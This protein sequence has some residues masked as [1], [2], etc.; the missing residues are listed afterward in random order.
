MRKSWKQKYEEEV[1]LMTRK[2]E[3][4]NQCAVTVT[5]K[6]TP[7]ETAYYLEILNKTHNRKEN[8]YGKQKN[9]HNA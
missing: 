4:L 2:Y 5:R 8:T 9:Q 7:E 3:Q 6:A 1:R